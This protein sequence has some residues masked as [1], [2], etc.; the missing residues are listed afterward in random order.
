VA[1]ASPRSGNTGRKAME[2]VSV[3]RE[4]K[5]VA[6][7]NT[8]AT[9]LF[10]VWCGDMK[11]TKQRCGDGPAGNS[12]YTHSNNV[13]PGETVYARAIGEYRY[14]ACEGG[15]SFGKDEIKDQPDGSFVCIARGKKS[16]S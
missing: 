14:A 7:T 9:P 6:F 12:F 1:V 15:I 16:E 2:C 5:D 4:G 13:K 8:C 3:N 10:V 11:Y